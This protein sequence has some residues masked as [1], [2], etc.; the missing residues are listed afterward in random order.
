MS[1][2]DPY[3]LAEAK[4]GLGDIRA[5]INW[6]KLDNEDTVSL[7]LDHAAAALDEGDVRLAVQKLSRAL[8]YATKADRA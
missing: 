5:E 3:Y 1:D 8:M 6:R 2:S 4:R 7:A